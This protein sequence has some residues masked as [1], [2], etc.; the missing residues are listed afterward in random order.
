MAIAMAS[1][2]FNHLGRSVTPIFLS[3]SRYYVQLSPHCPQMNKNSM[4]DIK[5][6]HLAP[7][8]QVKLRSLNANLFFKVY[9]TDF[10]LFAR[11]NLLNV[12]ISIAKFF[13]DSDFPSSCFDVPNASNFTLVGFKSARPKAGDWERLWCHFR[14]PSSAKNKFLRHFHIF[15]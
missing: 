5:S 11:L 2:G 13:F 4:W 7:A 6:C 12:L 15:L 14:T 1:P 8:R 10:F 9:M 3:R